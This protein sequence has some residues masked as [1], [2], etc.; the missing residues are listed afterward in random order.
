MINPFNHFQP[1]DALVRKLKAARLIKFGV[2]ISASV[3]VLVTQA[4][5]KITIIIMERVGVTASSS[6]D[7]KIFKNSMK[8]IASVAVVIPARPVLSLKFG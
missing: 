4:A 7:A 3:S 1:V 8:M 5:I 6:Q 2:R